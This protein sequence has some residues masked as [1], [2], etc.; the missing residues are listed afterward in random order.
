[1]SAII[2]RVEFGDLPISHSNFND[3]FRLLDRYGSDKLLTHIDRN[4][5]VGSTGLRLTQAPVLP[6][7]HTTSGGH[8]IVCDSIIDNRIELGSALGLST[9]DTASTSDAELIGAAF[10]RWGETCPH[11]LLG[12][13]AFACINRQT[14]KIFLARDH[15][16]SRPLFWAI[17]DKSF[18]FS[19]SIEA[20][21][22]FKEFTW[23]ID[24]AVVTEFLFRPSAPTSKPFFSEVD[25]LTPG[26]SIQF[27]GKRPTE[28]RW[29]TPST[30]RR[31][32]S[33]CSAD[34]VQETLHLV[35][36][37]VAQRTNSVRSVGA[38]FSGGIDSSA[39]T[40]LASQSLQAS[41][42]RLI[43]AYAWT[44]S[45][46]KAYPL[47]EKQDE[48]LLIQRL[49]KQYDLKMR[50]GNL[51]GEILANFQDRPIEFEGEAD[52]ADEL[53]IASMAK[54]DGVGIMLS[55]WGGDE[56]FSSH[57]Y[58][59]LGHLASSRKF[60]SALRFIRASNVSLKSSRVVAALC[61]RELIHPLLPDSIYHRLRRH[62][63]ILPT[64]LADSS[65]ADRH[66]DAKWGMNNP[67]KFGINP[68]R[69][70]YRHLQW[71][72]ITRRMESWAVLSAQYGFQYRYPLTDRRLLE[73]IMTLHPSDL[74]LEDEPRGMAKAAV[75]D[76][77]PRDAGKVD[78]VNETLRHDARIDAIDL[79]ANE[80][81]KGGF[82]DDCPWIDKEAFEA[83]LGNPASKKGGGGLLDIIAILSAVRVWKLYRR[84]LKNGWV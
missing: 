38:H 54:S 32:K 8:L 1:M 78:H 51:S 31:K 42:K 65:F 80:F 47:R 75:S 5:A 30:E 76:F 73:F 77:L 43:G 62:E 22:H 67:L 4:I 52:L 69:N 49:A 9:Q 37:A 58:G 57:G 82:S 17:R 71:G 55:G 15:I 70:I 66:S 28:T 61:W 56:A 10:E 27:S 26:S 44:P 24:E 34:T 13:Y 72:H 83:V 16:G 39:V 81:A 29:W 68:N 84:A 25:A 20:L 12:D 3:A 74:Y 79:L 41:G 53:S 7:V 48:R 35:E 11:Y 46:S 2:G 40:I 21:V 6:H 36:N 19:T 45:P 63:D 64:A 33:I 23:S 60:K 14:R 59:Y 50:Y 18:L